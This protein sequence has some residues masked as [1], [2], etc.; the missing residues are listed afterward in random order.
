VWQPAR[1]ISTASVPFSGMVVLWHLQVTAYQVWDN[2][3]PDT[4]TGLGMGLPTLP[5]AVSFG[6]TTKIHSALQP[7]AYQVDINNQ[8]QNEP[9]SDQVSYGYS[10][11]RKDMAAV[12][13][14]MDSAVA[15]TGTGFNSDSFAF[16][17]NIQTCAQELNVQD[18]G[19]TQNANTFYLFGMADIPVIETVAPSYGSPK[20]NNTDTPIGA[21]FSIPYDY[22]QPSQSGTISPTDLPYGVV[23]SM[24]N[25]PAG[26][27]IP[28][29]SL[30]QIQYQLTM[31]SLQL[32]YAVSP[33]DNIFSASVTVFDGYN[34]VN[35]SANLA[36]NG[37]QWVV[38]G[39]NVVT[40]LV[41]GE[42]VSPSFK[43]LRFWNVWSAPLASNKLVANNAN[44]KP[45][46]GGVGG[47]GPD[48]AAAGAS[49][50]DV[51]GERILSPPSQF[52]A[53]RQLAEFVTGV[54]NFPEFGFLYFNVTTDTVP[55]GSRVFMSPATP[56]TAQQYCSIKSSGTPF[57]QP[58]P[59]AAIFDSG[60][61]QAQ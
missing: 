26:T 49:W 46:S 52:P 17:R 13:V 40:V 7:F 32:Q 44:S 19:A 59:S 47:W 11:D 21:D 27:G 16:A 43:T 4:T 56:I 41:D 50:V 24:M 38:H 30:N 45:R 31:K 20:T 1:Y 28:S 14:V 29:A 23:H 33:T 6:P 37:S 34:E 22:T 57:Q 48:T 51:P 8:L 2:V 35:N 60:W 10:S 9:R 42:D 18:P 55:G 54:A 36:T 12:V 39:N 5:P 61:Q 25:L 15:P 53:D 58:N 3:V